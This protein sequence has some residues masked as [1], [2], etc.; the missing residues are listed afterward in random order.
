VAADLPGLPRGGAA[1]RLQVPEPARPHPAGSQ[2][3]RPDGPRG[4][5]TGAPGVRGPRRK[6]VLYYIN[7]CPTL[8]EPQSGPERTPPLQAEAGIG[9]NEIYPALKSR[10]D[11]ILAA[12]TLPFTGSPFEFETCPSGN[13]ALGA[14][15]GGEIAGM[16]VERT[17]AVHGLEETV[18]YLHKIEM[19]Q[20]NDV[21]YIECRTCHE[22]CLGGV[23]TAVDKYVAKRN[24]QAMVR[25][26]GLGSRLP[27]ETILRLYE[28]GRF[29]PDQG[30]ARLTR[31]FGTR[32]P[33]LS[34]TQLNRIEKLL[35]IIEGR[36]CGACG[37]PDCR[38]LAED[39]VRGEA[40]LEDCIWLYAGSRRRPGNSPWPAQ[41]PTGE[42][43][44]E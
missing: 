15:T 20:L 4:P 25:E 42:G 26:Y 41:R 29:R 12:D 7:P 30:P 40:K 38:A 44:A 22:G 28:K 23:L 10:V 19:G 5:G 27:R 14:M 1:D 11:R 37:A 17:L 43:E 2:A 31:I 35:E 39:V 13:A 6:T 16:D 18:A 9:I 8:A 32:K 34:L 36:D 3:G 33:P 21:E 24:V